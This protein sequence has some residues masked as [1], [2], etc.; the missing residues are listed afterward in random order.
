VSGFN[1][2]VSDG[3]KYCGLSYDGDTCGHVGRTVEPQ[4]FVSIDKED[5]VTVES[6]AGYHWDTLDDVSDELDYPAEQYA[7]LGPA[8]AVDSLM[9]SPL[10]DDVTDIP[11]IQYVDDRD[12]NG[13]LLIWNEGEKLK[14]IYNEGDA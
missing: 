13:G 12:K 10:F 11:P 14:R 8:S 9:Q 7:W 5:V 6:V 4:Y 1:F 2:V 3:C